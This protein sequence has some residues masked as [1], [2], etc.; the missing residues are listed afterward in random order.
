M[1]RRLKPHFLL[2]GGFP[3][4]RRVIPYTYRNIL[5]NVVQ[6][7]EVM[8]NNGE[9]A[10]SPAQALHG[11]DDTDWIQYQQAGFSSDDDSDGS[12]SNRGGCVRGTRVPLL[13]EQSPTFP[14]LPHGASGNSTLANS[15]PNV[16]GN[17]VNNNNI[18]NGVEDFTGT[19]P[20]RAPATL[21]SLSGYSAG[22][23]PTTKARK[24]SKK[25]SNGGHY[26]KYGMRQNSTFADKDEHKVNVS[27][28]T[29]RPRTTP[30]PEEN[31]ILGVIYGV[32]LWADMN[33]ATPPGSRGRSAL[34]AGARTAARPVRLGTRASEA[35]NSNRDE[36]VDPV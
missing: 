13:Q 17:G 4:I 16:L 32:L 18:N 19:T 3:V 5:G 6:T 23:L 11:Y 31:S 15:M 33:A 27:C 10:T 21:T 12:N 2:Y 20:A 25:G 28:C 8:R 22:A 26:N 36:R 14:E 34:C 9:Q 35:V 7:G 30:S 24:K 1:F 29:L